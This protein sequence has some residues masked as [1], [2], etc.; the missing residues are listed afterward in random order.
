MDI[1]DPQ[2][3]AIIGAAMAVH[4]E[5]GRGF[6]EAVYHQALAIELKERGIPFV[7]EVALPVAYKGQPLE[8]FFRADFICFGE[9]V[10]ELKAI[11]TTT[12]ADIAQLINYIKATGLQRGLLLNF[13]AKSLQFERRVL[14]YDE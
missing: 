12:K 7:R 11:S 6:L 13:G 10:V 3:H 8:A 14:D 1:R 9:V 4:A 2:T 5:L